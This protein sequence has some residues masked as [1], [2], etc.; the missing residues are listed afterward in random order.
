MN[1]D[2]ESGQGFDGNKVGIESEF[3]S[4][5]IGMRIAFKRKNIDEVNRILK[6]VVRVYSIEVATRLVSYLRETEPF[7]EKDYARR[8][9]RVEKQ[10]QETEWLIVHYDDVLGMIMAFEIQEEQPLD[11]NLVFGETLDHARKRIPKGYRED[12]VWEENGQVAIFA[13]KVNQ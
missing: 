2:Q 7:I 4:Y 8:K 1:R 10:R 5:V 11:A 9:R 3:N 6:R 12:K 13:V